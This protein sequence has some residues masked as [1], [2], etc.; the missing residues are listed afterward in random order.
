M[1]DHH[2]P[3]NSSLRTDY[4]NSLPFVQ[5][6]A[7]CRYTEPSHCTHRFPPGAV[8]PVSAS[9]SYALCS[10]DGALR[11]APTV[12]ASHTRSLSYLNDTGQYNVGSSN[13]SHSAPNCCVGNTVCSF[14]SSNHVAC[15]FQ[16]Q[17]PLLNMQQMQYNRTAGNY[18]TPLAGTDRIHLHTCSSG[19]YSVKDKTFDLPV[20]VNKGLH[21][22]QT[23]DIC[24]T[25][26]CSTDTNSCVV[27]T[28]VNSSGFNTT[29]SAV[30]CITGSSTVITNSNPVQTIVINAGA[31]QVAIA[32]SCAT[33]AVPPS[34]SV[35]VRPKSGR[36]KTNAE[37]KKQL[38]ER[39]EQQRLREQMASTDQSQI[40][41]SPGVPLAVESSLITKLSGSND[42]V[43]EI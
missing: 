7:L 35:V 37:L 21:T 1:M 22:A 40:S 9:S 6:P 28:G 10:G 27:G 36:A 23:A 25:C 13:S 19:V 20:N 8:L 5:S 32:A 18:T 39:R 16:Q 17:S 3:Y 15:E 30:V 12:G 29:Q 43:R 4:T 14:P 42:K 24:R 26:L 34:T 38:M 2:R 33:G 31:G 11:Y 41:T